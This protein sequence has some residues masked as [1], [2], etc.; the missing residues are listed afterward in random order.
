ML[1]PHAQKEAGHDIC[2]DNAVTPFMRWQPF[3]VEACAC[4]ESV[5]KSGACRCPKSHTMIEFLHQTI[6]ISSIKLP[7]PGDLVWLSYPLPWLT[8]GP[9]SLH[10]VLWALPMTQWSHVSISFCY[11]SGAMGCRMGSLRLSPDSEVWWCWCCGMVLDSWIM[12]PKKMSQL[13]SCVFQGW[14]GMS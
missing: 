9:H 11:G 10:L 6:Y 14:F 3:Y 7:M 12:C 5:C 1:E 4:S 8:I 2:E 13:D